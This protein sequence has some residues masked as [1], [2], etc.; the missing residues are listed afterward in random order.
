MYNV[1]PRCVV[2][3]RPIASQ[4]KSGLCNVCYAHEHN[5]KYL[6]KKNVRRNSDVKYK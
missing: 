5:R 3:R 2:C 4:N 6:H 1:I